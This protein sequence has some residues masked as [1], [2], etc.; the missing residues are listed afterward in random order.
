MQAPQT[1]RLSEHSRLY[2]EARE[3]AVALRREA[4]D[5]AARSLRARI[6]RLLSR[7]TPTAPE[8][9]CHS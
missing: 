3:R 7:Q 5:D 2:E 4:M 8:V 1:L 6:A 9:A